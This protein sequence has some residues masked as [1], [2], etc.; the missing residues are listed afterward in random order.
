M[1]KQVLKN[2]VYLSVTLF[3]CVCDSGRRSLMV[4][5]FINISHDLIGAFIIGDSVF[6]FCVVFLCDTLGIG[7]PLLSTS[8]KKQKVLPLLV[9][10]FLFFII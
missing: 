6:R 4:D 2:I 9:P 8:L 7:I 1:C 10:D 3:D 5:T